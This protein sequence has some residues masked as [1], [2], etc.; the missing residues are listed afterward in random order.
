MTTSSWLLQV[1]GLMHTQ[2]MR[3]ASG[4][5]G[6]RGSHQG[7]PAAAGAAASMLAQLLWAVGRTSARLHAVCGHLV[8][9][10]HLSS[11][12]DSPAA[13]C[14]PSQVQACCLVT[15]APHTAYSS[16]LSRAAGCKQSGSLQRC[17][18]FLTLGSLTESPPAGSTGLGAAPAWLPAGPAWPAAAAADGP[19]S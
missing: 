3:L 13:C 4:R 15:C 12:V 14:V 11:P 8:H 10:G 7:Q 16:H 9:A 19:L 6:M 17:S 1:Q 5:S 18:T 2:V